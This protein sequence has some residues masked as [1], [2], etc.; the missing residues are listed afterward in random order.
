MAVIQLK[1]KS[2]WTK[3][4]RSWYYDTYYTDIYGNRKE[5]KSKL[6]LRRKHAEEAE[7]VFLNTIQKED[8]LDS[9][10]SFE[11]VFNEWLL[12]KRKV[13]K[14]TTYYRLE[15][16]LG[17][18][19]LEFFKDYKLH[20]IKTNVINSWLVWLGKNNSNLKYQNSI[21]GYMR[22]LLNYAKD[23]YDFD[24]KVIG[25]IQKYRIETISTKKKDSEWNFWTYEEFNKFI[26]YVD[27]KLYNLIFHFLYYT[28]LRL[29]EMIALT[30]E[31]IDLEKRTL[32]IYKNFTN[33]LGNNSYSILD[34]K[35]KN[36]VRV[37]DL[38]DKLIKMLKQHR[39]EEEKLYS[40]NEKMFLFGNVKYI[41]PTSLA[42]KLEYYINIS[43]VKRIT[44]HG[45]RHS[46]VSLLIFL[47]CDSRDVAERIGD[48]VQ[49]VEST[50][51]HMF[52]SKKSRT[53]NVLNNLKNMQNYDIKTR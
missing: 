33:K 38:D 18:N 20:S 2:K 45:F 19:I 21:I 48:T 46:H 34:P 25:K 23:N 43:Q 47:G 17:K 15:K 13:V 6:Y 14:S 10:I 41:P 24:S 16:N 4:G 50:Y 51:Y 5:K 28:G 53:V 35:T 1:D 27:D 12:Y 8:V 31:D 3:D 39:K 37:I 9:N 42:R 49:M 32:K 44:P 52:P 11:A 36:S 29:G 40:F 22:E 7:R 30:W 26:S